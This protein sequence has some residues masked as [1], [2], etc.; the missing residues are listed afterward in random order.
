MD[1]LPVPRK[2][3]LG[4]DQAELMSNALRDAIA[5]DPEVRARWAAA[6]HC[7]LDTWDALESQSGI[8]VYGMNLYL[9]LREEL[10]HALD[11]KA[12]MVTH[13]F[14]PLLPKYL[15]AIFFDLEGRPL[16]AD[17]FPLSK[18]KRWRYLPDN[19][20]VL[21]SDGSVENFSK[22]TKYHRQQLDDYYESL[23]PL[24]VG[25]RTRG[26]GYITMEKVAEAIRE[27]KVTNEPVLQKTVAE[28]LGVDERNLRAFARREGTTWEQL[29][30]RG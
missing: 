26:S 12:P 18:M 4:D 8:A 22:T 7:F 24:D 23:E 15:P 20:A 19:P 1:R 27:I 11:A 14:G 21:R 28:K 30:S 16:P 29:K 10:V 6:Q 5:L 13:G 25:G 3:Q 17:I 9:R 2:T